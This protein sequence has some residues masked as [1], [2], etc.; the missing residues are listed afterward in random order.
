MKYYELTFASSQMLTEDSWKDMVIL[1]A[2]GPAQRQRRQA[3]YGGYGA[4]GTNSDSLPSASSVSD[5]GSFPGL[6]SPLIGF[7]SNCKCSTE[8]SCPPGPP[9]IR[10]E[11]G[12]DGVDGLPGKDAYDGQDA[13]DFSQV[14][15][16]IFSPFNMLIFVDYEP[17][18]V[19]MFSFEKKKISIVNSELE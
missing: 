6:P 11:Q 3:Q 17:L 12:P 9:G 10:G 14:C 5:F 13:E 7:G 16:E 15:N 18:F 2:G 8:N 19:E 1:G 4:S